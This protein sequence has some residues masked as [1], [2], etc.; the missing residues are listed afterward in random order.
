MIVKHHFEENRAF[1]ERAGND[2]H[3]HLV[4]TNCHSVTEYKDAELQRV[5]LNKK[6]KKF[7]PLH[8]A[9]NVSGL[10]SECARQLKKNKKPKPQQKA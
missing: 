6:I 7:K 8:Y 2:F 4:C 1:Y 5:I 3:L 9:L 10:C